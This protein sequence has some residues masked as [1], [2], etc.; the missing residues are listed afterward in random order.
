MRRTLPTPPWKT[1]LLTSVIALSVAGCTTEPPVAEQPIAEDPATAEPAPPLTSEVAP[2]VDG[3]PADALPEVPGGRGAWEA[4]PYLDTEWVAETNGQRVTG[5]GVD[6]RFSTP[7]CVFWSYPEEPQLTVLVREMASVDEAIAVVDWA[8]PIDSTEPAE[9]PLDWSGGRRGGSAESGALYA[10]Q[11]DSVA[12]VVFTN[13]DQSL[14]AQLVAEE[15]I[16][17]LGL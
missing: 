4:C 3:L 7:A 1:L 5:L 8:A 10:V 16:G 12:V 2:V 17:N 13:Q 14:K 9:E 6:E 11:K 15:V